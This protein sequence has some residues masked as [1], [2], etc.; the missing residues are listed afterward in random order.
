MACFFEKIARFFSK[1]KFPLRSLYRFSDL[2]IFRLGFKNEYWHMSL[3][4][5]CLFV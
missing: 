1:I 3:R 4:G 2:F 5:V